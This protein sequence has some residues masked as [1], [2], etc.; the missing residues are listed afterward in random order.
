MYEIGGELMELEKEE[1]N[2]LNENLYEENANLTKVVELLREL[3]EVEAKRALVNTAKVGKDVK[4][5]LDTKIQDIK[6]WIESGERKYGPKQGLAKE[7]EK[8]YANTVAEIYETFEDTK[9]ECLER[10]ETYQKVE[11]YEYIN[12]QSSKIERQLYKKT[13]KTLKNDVSEVEKS[14]DYKHFCDII[15]KTQKDLQKA[16]KEMD[17][18]KISSLNSDLKSFQKQRENL[19]EGKKETIDEKSNEIDELK[20]QIKMSKQ[21]LIDTRNNIKNEYK[22]IDNI[23]KISVNAINIAEKNKNKE[24]AVIERKNTVTKF[25]DSVMSKVGGTKKFVNNIV[26]PIKGEIKTLKEEVIPEFKANLLIDMTEK[27]IK[28][29]NFLDN[30]KDNVKQKFQNGKDTVLNISEGVIT[31]G[32]T[33][34]GFG[35]DIATIVVST[36]YIAGYE[37]TNSA[38][39]AVEKAIDKKDQIK[40]NMSNTARNIIDN[41]KVAKTSFLNSVA[42]KI[43]EKI[44]IGRDDITNKQQNTINNE[45]IYR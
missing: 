39:N 23:A 3:T 25:L 22:S 12:I 15:S 17:T 1:N 9:K 19:F 13:V 27:E 7:I 2:Y 21:N 5:G 44:E 30:A 29:N 10:K 6:N 34:A 35:K 20:L 31:A 43:K 42:K 37:I 28:F 45:N 40:E 14:D 36:G 4:R 38:N 26:D 16:V 33:M 32:K 18:K 11:Q 41:G 24:L 8:E